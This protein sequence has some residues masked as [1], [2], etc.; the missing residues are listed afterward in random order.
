[1][2]WKQLSTTSSSPLQWLLSAPFSSSCPS[3]NLLCQAARP[4]Q[5]LQLND[6]KLLQRK[7]RNNLRIPLDGCH[8]LSGFSSSHSFCSSVYVCWTLALHHH[9][10]HSICNIHTPVSVLMCMLVLL[11]DMVKGVD[12]RDA[13]FFFRERRFP[14]ASLPP[15][16]QPCLSAGHQWC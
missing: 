2:P 5:P 11:E 4:S 14:D 1:M 6:K 16:P 7:T 12:T 8:F 15:S 3:K 9:P 13:T 10:L